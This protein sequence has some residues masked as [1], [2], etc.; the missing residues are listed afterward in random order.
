MV[1][2]D[3]FEQCEKQTDPFLGGEG[4]FGWLLSNKPLRPV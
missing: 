2:T 4:H 1:S 3:Q